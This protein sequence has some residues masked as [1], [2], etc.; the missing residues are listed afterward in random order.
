[1]LTREIELVLAT[2]ENTANVGWMID[3][4][5]PPTTKGIPF[6]KTVIEGANF[7]EADWKDQCCVRCAQIHWREDHS[8][9]WLERHMEMTQGFVIMGRNP[10]LLVL[11]EPTHDRLD[12]SLEARQLPD[13]N[14]I[15]AYIVPPGFGIIIKKGT[16]HDF[17]VSC[18]A[19]VSAFVINTREVVA[20]LQAKKEAG[21]MN[22]GDCF[23]LRMSDHWDFR[24]T[25]PDP[26]PFVQQRRLISPPL[27]K[28]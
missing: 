8:V 1:M 15:K 28:L 14:T 9:S 7:E 2:R 24:M 23:K 18:G 12:L 5:V 19:P 17:P 10:G 11:G 3:D 16:W 20:A 6:Y 27:A 22:E 26:R 13:P 25:F 21:P 4:E